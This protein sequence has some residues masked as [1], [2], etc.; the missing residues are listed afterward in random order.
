MSNA[1]TPEAPEAPEAPEE[2]T[3]IE[4]RNKGGNKVETND[5]EASIQAGIAAGW[6][7]KDSRVP[8]PPKAPE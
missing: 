4:W 8:K 2:S 7:S 5:R 1:K 6:T 3:T